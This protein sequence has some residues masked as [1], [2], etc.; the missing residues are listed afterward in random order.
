M[1]IA[2]SRTR[3]LVLC[4]S[5]PRE[6]AKG[7]GMNPML[8]S[9]ANFLVSQSWQISLVFGLVL[10]LTWGLRNASSHLRYLLWLVVIAK[11][12]I[13]PFVNVPIVTLPVRAVVSES[14]QG[15]LMAPM[16]RGEAESSLLLDRPR[17]NAVSQLRQR[18][19][20]PAAM[21]VQRSTPSISIPLE[22][23]QLLAIVWMVFVGMIGLYV[24]GKIWAVQR[25]LWRT[26]EMADAETT[27]IVASLATAMEMRHPPNVFL[28]ESAAQPFVWGWV[29]GDLYLP[30]EFTKIGS[31]E[32][33][34]A[35]LM[36][37]LAHVARW[38]ALVNLIQIV[39][40]T[41]FFFHP[42]VW[43][44]NARIRQEREKCCDEI[45]L[46]GYGIHPR[47]YCEAIVQML[48][49]EQNADYATP[50][51]AVTGSTKQIADRIRLI[52]NSRRKFLRHPNRVAFVAVLL[53]AIVLLPTALIV[54]THA[55]NRVPP[56]EVDNQTVKTP[57]TKGESDV[58]EA[59][60]KVAAPV[61]DASALA[62]ATWQ[63]GQTVELQVVHAQTKK[64]IPG[65]KLE[66]QYTGKGINFENVETQS[67]DVEGR[68]LIRLPDRPTT[69]VRVYPTKAGFVPLRVYW[70][71][72]PHV[73]MPKSV[74]I[75]LE[76][77]RLFG[78][79]IRDESGKPISGVTVDIHYWGPGANPHVR[80]NVIV[81]AT[82]DS[83]GRWHVDMMPSEVDAQQ[84]KI[85][86]AHPDYIS[87]RPKR[88]IL[89]IP[90]TPQ[91]SIN[92]LFDQTA[93][94]VMKKGDTVHGRV[95]DLSGEPLA[96]VQL[97]EDEYYWFSPGTPRATTDKDGSFHIRGVEF[98][99]HARADRIAMRLSVH[100]A[101]Y[102]P[103]L[104]E[105]QPASP[106]R[107][108]LKPGKSVKG[109]VVDESGQPIE[110]VHVGVSRWH[111]QNN[112]L[113]LKTETNSDGAFHLSDVPTDRVEYRIGKEG[114]LW[115][116]SFA[117]PPSSDEYSITLKSP[118]RVSGAIV[119]AETGKPLEKASLIRGTS[120]D[121][122][123]AP[124]WMRYDAKITT[125]GRYETAFVQKTFSWMLRVEADGY[126]PGISRVFRI[127]NPDTGKV[128][129]DFKLKKAEPIQGAIIGLG[130]KP[131][132][133]A[134]V[135][136][137][138]QDLNMTDRKI[139]S[140]DASR[141]Q[142]DANGRFQFPP[143]VEPFCL[144]VVHEDGVAMVTESE[145]EK[146]APQ[147]QVRPWTKKNETQQI[148]RKP[149][150]GQWV[151][152]PVQRR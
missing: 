107:I 48:A 132:T 61:A 40:Q 126:A 130:G 129:F 57:D 124:A 83:A 33:R 125:N 109:R 66:L 21:A 41:L 150:P 12:L 65:V 119:D 19:H 44:A 53:V 149:A 29:R 86:L 79:T 38:D 121:D 76:P 84:L 20:H 8:N 3:V 115:V 35:I 100:A 133:G 69:E 138:T 70:T 72:V 36:H 54:A 117:M 85:Y 101:G 116:E 94:M 60:E 73:T 95:V 151:D 24:S 118:L 147:I 108:E 59:S 43:W 15:D 32:Q 137:A 2:P 45:V 131:L 93:A 64:P 97:Y 58:K 18:E 50:T 27:T 37:E 52:L 7:G 17:Q 104:V 106:L 51:L 77:G 141:T 39:V 22:L 135:Y 56:S 6:I 55:E 136:L 102:T 143:E 42:L 49:F 81:K 10:L 111:G 112:R 120:Y 14:A 98:N 139:S 67:T 23:H 62:E 99:E 110:R 114:Y 68:S 89:P 30:L 5:A 123:R 122:G 71:D 148:I 87:D 63:P 74:T 9:A 146:E 152:F 46:S 145:F 34:R 91:P 31:I 113:D 11:C 25:R 47:D 127:D 4:P 103:Q 1:L 13:P 144:V 128:K 142:T 90:V 88:A 82:S 26:R 80:P 28:A 96:G 92:S 75:P 105:V 16:T 134:D 78:G 140:H